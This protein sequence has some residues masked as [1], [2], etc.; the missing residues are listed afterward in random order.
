MEKPSGGQAKISEYA[1]RIKNN[2]LKEDVCKD[3]PDLFVSAIEE[4]LEKRTK[5][6]QRTQ[7]LERV[8]EIEEK[9][10]ITKITQPESKEKNEYTSFKMK[11]GETDE[12]F[13]WYEYRNEKA[14]EMKNSGEFK[15]GEERIYFD[16][17]YSDIEKLRNL[18]I[19]VAADNKIPIGFKYIDA[20]KTY[21]VHKDGTETR[22]VTNFASLDDAKKFF[23]TLK[24]STE[25]KK[26]TTDRKLDYKGIR[27]DELAEYASG[28][29]ETRSALERIINAH[30]NSSGNYE[31]V[32]ESGRAII[33]TK[34]EYNNF[35]KTY[36]ELSEK[37]KKIEKE[38]EEVK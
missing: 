37:I 28:F 10:G 38:W 20:E 9:L 24:N 27:I 23:T 26:F 19:Q 25:Y 30:L 16:I 5:E 14:K 4:E 17:P 36:Q 31:Y 8:S 7:E 35:Q 3:L 1:D 21:P 22:F 34:E 18:T 12:G 33:I 15:W 6:E 11:N 29:R 13:F 2:E 32:A